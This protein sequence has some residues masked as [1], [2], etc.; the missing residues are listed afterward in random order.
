MVLF[1]TK[2]EEGA[3]L[4]AD[5]EVLLG[6]FGFAGGYDG[7]FLLV[8]VEF[9]TLVLQVE[10]GSGGLDKEEGC[11]RRCNALVLRRYLVCTTACVTHC[12]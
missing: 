1:P 2:G 3:G 9:V 12:N 7:D 6:D 8:L 10:D 5:A 4:V 11:V